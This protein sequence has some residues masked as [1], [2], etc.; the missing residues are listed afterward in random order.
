MLRSG[1]ICMSFLYNYLVS[2]ATINNEEKGGDILCKKATKLK[3]LVDTF[4]SYG[5]V[6]AKLSQIICLGENDE[7][8]ISVCHENSKEWFNQVMPLNIVENYYKTPIIKKTQGQ[9]PVFRVRLPSYKGNI[10][11]EIF[12]I[13]K[14]KLNDITCIQAGDLLVGIIEFNG[15]MFMSQNFTPC[16]ELHKIKLFKDN[17]VR[18]LTSGYIFSDMNE[19]VD[20]DNSIKTDNI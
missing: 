1:S 15:L 9:L 16:Y 10:L 4:Q 17:D 2:E 3:C 5:G 20:L 13:K 12:N 7:N 14:E 6:L 18:L 11:T 8:N 19:K